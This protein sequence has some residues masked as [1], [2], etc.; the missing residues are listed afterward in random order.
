MEQLRIERPFGIECVRTLID[1]DTRHG[2]RWSVIEFVA[3]ERHVI[4]SGVAR[5]ASAA[6]LECSDVLMVLAV[7]SEGQY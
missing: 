1:L 2:W 3:G 5:S 6:L 4:D 7:P